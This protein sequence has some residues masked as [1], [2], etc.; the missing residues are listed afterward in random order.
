MRPELYVAS[1]AGCKASKQHACHVYWQHSVPGRNH[2]VSWDGGG[3]LVSHNV[4]QRANRT[5]II[6][7]LQQQKRGYKKK[8]KET[9]SI[10]KEGWE[11]EE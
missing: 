9:R 1:I 7:L 3:V 11:E 4:V 6:D 2:S 8:R 5:E 10:I